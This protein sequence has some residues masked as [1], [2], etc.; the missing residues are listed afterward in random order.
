MEIGTIYLVNRMVKK[1]ESERKLSR[2]YQQRELELKYYDDINRHMEEIRMLRHEY[3][4]QL[5][6]IYDLLD[7]HCEEKA[8]EM[9]QMIYENVER[10][11]M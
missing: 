5:Q 1:V 7:N 3:A 6:V 11:G 2:L 8:E 10:R 9:I 4:N